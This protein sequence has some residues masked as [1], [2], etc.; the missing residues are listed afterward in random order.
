[1]EPSLDGGR[2]TRISTV[3]LLSFGMGV[4]AV[5]I[6]LKGRQCRLFLCCSVCLR[7]WAR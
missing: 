6:D 3:L 7:C 2:P 4:V 5:T 1:M